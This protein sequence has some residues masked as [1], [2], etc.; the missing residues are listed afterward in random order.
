MNHDMAICR[1]GLHVHL[2]FFQFFF[3]FHS[4]LKLEI[5]TIMYHYVKH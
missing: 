1:F 3:F 5:Q 4:S 2:Y